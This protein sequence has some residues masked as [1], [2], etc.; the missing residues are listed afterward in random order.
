MTWFIIL[1]KIMSWYAENGLFRFFAAIKSWPKK[2]LPL[3]KQINFLT[4]VNRCHN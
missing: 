2:Y 3:S 1:Q 4:N